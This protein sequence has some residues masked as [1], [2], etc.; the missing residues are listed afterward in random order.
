RRHPAASHSIKAWP[1]IGSPCFAAPSRQNRARSDR[2]KT[3]RRACMDLTGWTHAAERATGLSEWGDDHSF[4]EG[5]E[6]MDAAVADS[7]VVPAQGRRFERHALNHLATRL[8]L[9]DDQVA[10]PEVIDLR[11]EAPIIITGL[12]R[13]GSSLLQAL[14][15]SVQGARA[16][17]TWEVLAPWPAPRADDAATDPRVPAVQA[18][19]DAMLERPP[20]LRRMH[21]FGATFPAECN[22]FLTLHFTSANF[23]VLYG[24][25]RYVGWFASA[26]C[27]GRYLTHKR[28]LQQLQWHSGSARWVLK[29]AQHLL[30]LEDLLAAYPD[31]LVV[32]LHRDPDRA[33][34]SISRFAYTTAAAT[35]PWADPS[36]FRR[37]AAELWCQALRRAWSS[38]RDRA[39]E[40]RIV[41][42]GY[43]EL[44]ADPLGTVC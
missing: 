39:V 15:A 17:H 34:D 35:D 12:P 18:G 29:S 4:L 44:L 38:R 42:V 26:T 8:H 20:A 2:W 24:V 32:H 41:D 1:R 37:S 19:L 31:A 10:H 43:A 30:C 36:Y 11:I 14:L 21:P 25:P 7:S 22:D 28:V 40:A 3:T 13:T 6:V 33:I 9:V 23:W 27:S 16:P 5:L